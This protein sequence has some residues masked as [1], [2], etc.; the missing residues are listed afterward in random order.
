M[1]ILGVIPARSGSVSI[2][3]KNIKMLNDYPLFYYTL[4]Q[5]L[6]SKVFDRIIVSTD[7]KKY[8][9]LANKYGANTPFLRPKKLSKNNSLATDTIAYAVLQT[10]KYFNEKYDLVCMLQPTTPLRILSD[11]KKIISLMKKNFT[12]YDSIISVVDVDNFHPIK[13][14]KIINSQLTDY[15]YW[16]IENP[17]RQ[18][19]PKVYIVNGAFYLTK[20]NILINKKSFKGKKSLPFVMPKERSVNIDNILDFKL[21]AL[22]MKKLKIIF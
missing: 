5:S 6:N 4:K 20:R 13:M 19:L 1:K 7:S 2:K 11:F 14:K 8:L 21:A 15:E 17:P 16:P 10:E 9:N 22:M 3:N 18:T 12:I